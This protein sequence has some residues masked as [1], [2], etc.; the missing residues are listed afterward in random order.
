VTRRVHHIVGERRETAKAAAA[1]AAYRDLGPSRSLSRLRKQAAEASQNG[2][3]SPMPPTVSFKMLAEWCTAFNWVAYCAVHDAEMDA[4]R[5][6]EQARLVAE[7]AR[8]NSQTMQAVG[9]GA[10]GVVAVALGQFVDGRTGALKQDV[11]LRDI[12]HLMRAG[13]ELVALATGSPTT[14]VG[15]G[16]TVALEKILRECEEET[17]TAILRGMRAA[18]EWRERME[19]GGG[20]A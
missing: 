3:N 11:P 1:F 7:Q 15:D 19:R 8:Q 12:P 16:Q 18:L 5:R 10:L 20:A 14:I 2:G 17:R 6:A 4:I 13:A 9:A